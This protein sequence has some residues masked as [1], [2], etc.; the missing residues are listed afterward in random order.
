MNQFERV[1]KAI[2]MKGPDRVPVKHSTLPGAFLKYGKLLEEIYE[3]YPSDIIYLP[4]ANEEEY[5][6]Q[7]RVESM[8]RWGCVWCR[9]RDDFKGQVIKHPLE[10]WSSLSSYKFPDPL[11]WPEFSL[12]EKVIEKYGKTYYI[13]VDGDTLWQRM[14]YL[15]GMEKIFIDIVK[16]KNEVY[17]LRDKILEYIL[18]RIERI[19]NMGAD[20]IWFRDDWGTQNNIMIRPSVWRKIFK[21]AYQQM[22]KAV[23]EK[24]MHVFFH[25]DG[26][27]MPIIGDLI[28]IGA[29]VLNL[30][31]PTMDLSQIKQEFG[32][33]VCFLG[34]LDRQRIL[35]FGKPHD[36]KKHALE[37][38]EALGVYNG[39]YIG[40]G[41]VGP[42]VSLE[43]VETML[44][45]FYSYY[46]E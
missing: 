24:N 22:F 9:T 44:S 10:D 40:E 39:G 43:N 33:K 46:Y 32:G 7:L 25:S 37:I 4:M 14:F 34:G 17:I 16:D 41:E 42:D 26:M 36:V 35:P 13:L 6:P 12:A 18:V 19:G 38:I 5:S 21:P 2:E 29:D 8:D 31:L 11:N 27:I 1:V 3:R 20:G 30:Q 23:H 45:T 28:E 15:R